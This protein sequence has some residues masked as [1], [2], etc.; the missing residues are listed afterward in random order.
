MPTYSFTRWAGRHERLF[1]TDV[2]FDGGALVF[3]DGDRLVLAV[4][5]GDWNDLREVS[6]RECVASLHI[7]TTGATCSVCGAAGMQHE[8]DHPGGGR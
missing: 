1:A 6:W 8:A 2:S 4:K 7:P 5:P 3:R